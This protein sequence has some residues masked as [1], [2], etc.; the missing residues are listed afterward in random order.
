MEALYPGGC[1]VRAGDAHSQEAL[2]RIETD[3]PLD[4]PSEALSHV[5]VSSSV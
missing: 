1:L 3:E 2:L 4:R 5:L